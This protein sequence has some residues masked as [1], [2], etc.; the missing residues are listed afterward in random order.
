MAYPFVYQTEGRT[1]CSSLPDDWVTFLSTVPPKLLI[2]SKT[3]LLSTLNDPFIVDFSIRYVSLF[4]FTQQGIETLPFIGPFI[5]ERHGPTR[6]SPY[7]GTYTN[8]H[9]RVLIPL[10]LYIDDSN[11]SVGSA[12]VRFERSSL[13]EHEGTRTVVLR[14]LKIITPVKCVIPFYNHYIKEPKEGERHQRR[15]RRVTTKKSSQPVWS[16][17]ID[18]LTP[19]SVMTRALQ[20]LWE[21]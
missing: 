18:A 11:E 6:I 5:E 19:K 16:L 7:T 15:C 13:P 14:F 4:A 17:N 10:R 1:T 21:R 20:L 12:L 8:H 3:Q 2:R 9:L